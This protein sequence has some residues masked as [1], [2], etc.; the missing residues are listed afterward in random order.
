MNIHFSLKVISCDLSHS[1]MSRC[2][3][4]IGQFVQPPCN[5][6]VSRLSHPIR[7]Y[8]L[9]C[10][11]MAASW[12]FSF[13]RVSSLLWLSFL[14]RF[15]VVTLHLVTNNDAAQENAS[16]WASN[17][18]HNSIVFLFLVSVHGIQLAQILFPTQWNQL[19]AP[20]IIHRFVWMSFSGWSPF[21][22]LT[23]VQDRSSLSRTS[24]AHYSPPNYAHIDHSMFSQRRWVNSFRYGSIQ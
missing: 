16:L 11:P 12:P 23:D 17:S 24:E 22:V 7:Q 14:F 6:R 19:S 20:Y 1:K 18:S 21:C 9:F 4:Q 10:L 15:G 13:I 5:P 8:T 3:S 2:N